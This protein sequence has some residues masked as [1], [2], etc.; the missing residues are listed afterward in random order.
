M[1]RGMADFDPAAL[2][3]YRVAPRE[4]GLQRDRLSTEALARAVGT[5]KAQIVAYEQGRQVPEPPRI[6]ELA[7]ALGV[8]P[9]GLTHKTPQ[10]LK[11]LAHLR[12]ACGYCA[13]EVVTKI[14][15]SPKAYRKFETTGLSPARRPGLLHE[16]ADVLEVTPKWVETA[17]T[18]SPLVRSR[19]ETVTA[20]LQ[21]MRLDYVLDPQPWSAPRAEDDKVQQLAG[22][23]ARSPASIARLMTFVL[24]RERQRVLRLEKE[25]LTSVYDLDP[26]RRDRA[27]KTIVRIQVRHEREMTVFPG[28]LDSF[29]RTALP[30]DGWQALVQVRSTE[31]WMP[32]SKVGILPET[33]VRIP[34]PFLARRP[35]E[36]TDVE[37]QLTSAGRFH[38]SSFK[39]WY[40][41][42]Y[43]SVRVPELSHRPR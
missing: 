25:T 21:A 9:L 36:G 17:L 38:S 24:G 32:I 12:R 20:L 28:K 2:R 43:P 40:V 13:R 39:D 41:A 26:V 14:R 8:H 30:S 11:S 23:L 15:I 10:I 29:F 6:R 35:G 16:V 3:S 5:T 34:I 31:Q 1:A 22:M 42:L 4:A 37:V 19:V 18:N 33:L 27:R 7:K